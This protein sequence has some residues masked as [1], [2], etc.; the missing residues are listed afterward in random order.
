VGQREVVA[1]VSDDNDAVE[2]LRALAN[3]VGGRIA[4]Q[5]YAGS[6]LQRRD[7]GAAYLDL[8]VGASLVTRVH[9]L[10]P[11]ALG[12]GAALLGLRQ[13]DRFILLLHAQSAHQSSLVE[14]VARMIAR[15][16]ARPWVHVMCPCPA[17]RAWATQE[18][19]GAAGVVVLPIDAPA[20]G[21]AGLH[22]LHGV[23][24]A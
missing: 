13:V 15:L 19:R 3:Q 2:L 6:D 16:P 18:L 12:T 21:Y 23:L 4:Y 9:A 1:L 10:S 7:V 5:R 20:S 24:T 14:D 17:S 8:E 11:R 22:A